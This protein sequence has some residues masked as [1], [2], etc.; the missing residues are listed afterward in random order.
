MVI[1]NPLKSYFGILELSSRQLF[2]I[3]QF[4]L[5]HRRADHRLVGFYGFISPSHISVPPATSSSA[6]IRE[7]YCLIEHKS[8]SLVT[9]TSVL[10]AQQCALGA[11]SATG[12]LLRVTLLPTNSVVCHRFPMA[13][14]HFS[15]KTSLLRQELASRWLPNRASN[16]QLRTAHLPTKHSNVF[17]PVSSMTAFQLM[18]LANK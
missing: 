13:V 2:T 17:C 8:V 7:P 15:S 14:C 6:A 16:Y 1:C 18:G 3:R 10:I 12:A 5:V 4:H 9:F 11:F